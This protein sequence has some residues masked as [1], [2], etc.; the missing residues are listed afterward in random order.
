MQEVLE[1]AGI[2]PSD[3]KTYATSDIEDVL[4][5]EWGAKPEVMCYC[6]N[7]KWQKT[8]DTALI[9]SVRPCGAAACSLHHNF[10][11]ELRPIVCWRRS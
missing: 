5:K 1:A 10:G 2:V 9:D 8:C 7:G 4:A 11:V 6:P 3:T